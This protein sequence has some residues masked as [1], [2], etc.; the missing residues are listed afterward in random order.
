MLDDDDLDLAIIT[1]TGPG[2]GCIGAVVSIIVIGVVAYY[3]SQ[4][5]AECA[6]KHC[7]HGTPILTN[8][9][10]LCVEKAKP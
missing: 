5:K 6:E 10:C 7:D 3:V 8:H 9:Q 1:S 2:G 4:N